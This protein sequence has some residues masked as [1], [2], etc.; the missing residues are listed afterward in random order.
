MT[1]SSISAH[2]LIFIFA[3]SLC[4][5]QCSVDSRGI[6][7][8]GLTSIQN[9]LLGPLIPYGNSPW[10]FGDLAEKGVADNMAPAAIAEAPALGTACTG[11]VSLTSGNSYVTT[12][13]DMTACVASSPSGWMVFAW[14]SIDGT[15]TGRALCPVSSTTST[16]IN[17][18]EYL[19]QPS[20]SG[21]TAY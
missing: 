8:T 16:Q 14:N 20:F 13:A 11:T 10:I 5:A 15:G 3:A 12:T 1:S 19:N 21:I 18:S 9:N 17:C 4:S 6:C 2:V 7:N